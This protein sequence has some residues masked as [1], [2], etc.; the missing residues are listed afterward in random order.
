M[1]ITNARLRQSQ[2]GSLLLP[3]EVHREG[4][5]AAAVLRGSGDGTAWKLGQLLEGPGVGLRYPSVAQLPSG[6]VVLLA[7]TAMHRIYVAYSGDGSDS[8]SQPTEVTALV[9]PEAPAALTSAP[10][11]EGLI[12]VWNYHSCRG[13]GT[14]R[15]NLSLSRSTDGR[16]WSA[17]ARLWPEREQRTTHP[18]L[19]RIGE[20]LILTYAQL[21]ANHLSLRIASLA[22]E[23]GVHDAK[24][25]TRTEAPFQDEL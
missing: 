16:H 20:R 2:D 9:A 3:V 8:W 11:G 7:S 21:E 25:Q 6:E 1:E 14:D 15:A 10:D 4:R 17:A 5:S 23:E 12:V 18:A 19:T 24:A 22:S 13:F